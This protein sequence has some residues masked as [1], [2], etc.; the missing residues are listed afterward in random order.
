MVPNSDILEQ[1]ESFTTT[2]PTEI[3]DW[4]LYNDTDTIIIIWNDLGE[5]IYGSRLIEE[6]FSY[7]M[8]DL[9]GKQWTFLLPDEVADHIKQHF[10]E[11]EQKLHIP[12]IKIST[13][14]GMTH[15]FNGIIDKIKI[16]EELFSICKLRNITYL[17]ELKQVL[18]D[19]EKLVL[20]GQLSAGL[21]HEIRN[22]L[23]SLKG[24]LQLVQAGVKQREEYY[25]VMIGEIDKLEKIT[26]ELL[27]LAKPFESSKKSE[28]IYQ[29]I[30]DVLFLLKTQTDLR[31]VHFEVD[32]Q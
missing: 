8:D 17:N 9:I 20:A 29:M 1:H 3:M 25:R 22:P 5:I 32:L 26:S 12:N 10:K 24:F 30:E 23:T 4:Y 28:Y 19:S 18:L 21:V 15:A 11:G 27:N 16:K 14:K 13:K 7:K 2:F 31:N 6:Y